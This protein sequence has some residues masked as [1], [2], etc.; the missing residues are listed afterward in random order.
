MKEGDN[1][2]FVDWKYGARPVMAIVA[3][4]APGIV[5]VRQPS[6]GLLHSFDMPIRFTLFDL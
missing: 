3:V 5:T 4:A 6:L 2:W 1:V